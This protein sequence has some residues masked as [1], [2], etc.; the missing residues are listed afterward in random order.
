MKQWSGTNNESKSI[1]WWEEKEK[2][3]NRESNNFLDEKL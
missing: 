3:E 2:T 1:Q